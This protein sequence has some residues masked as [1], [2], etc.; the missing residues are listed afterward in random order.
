MQAAYQS[1]GL[2]DATSSSR[3][4]S[5]NHDEDSDDTDFNSGDEYSDAAVDQELDAGADKSWWQQLGPR[6][7][8]GA[9]VDYREDSLAEELLAP[10]SITVSH[11]SLHLT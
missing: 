11:A 4:A 9:R 8:G 7:R 5:R 6:T 10:L 3:T 1:D 2:D